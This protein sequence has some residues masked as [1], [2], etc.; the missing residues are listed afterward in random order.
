MHKSFV[1]IGLIALAGMLTASTAL[2]ASHPRS[3]AV[4]EQPTQLAKDDA[5]APEAGQPQTKKKHKAS[6]K[7]SH[8]KDAAQ[9]AAPAEK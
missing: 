7:R 3:A 4:V 5:K 2:A 8:G 6:K 9:G 1:G